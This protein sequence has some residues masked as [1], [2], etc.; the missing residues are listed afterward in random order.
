MA[1]NSRK[2]IEEDEITFTFFANFNDMPSNW[3]KQRSTYVWISFHKD[4]DFE[5]PYC[6]RDW[7]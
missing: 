4:T 1:K 3:H 2:Q 7:Q 6:D 5:E